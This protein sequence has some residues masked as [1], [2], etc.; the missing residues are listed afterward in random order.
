MP[1]GHR[2][3]AGARRICNQTVLLRRN[4]LQVGN[5]WFSVEQY[6]SEQLIPVKTCFIC[7]HPTYCGQPEEMFLGDGL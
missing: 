7:C 2:A 4:P 6:E 5:Y 3:V 1:S